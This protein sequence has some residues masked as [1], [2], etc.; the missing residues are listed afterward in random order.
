[1]KMHLVQVEVACSQQDTNTE[2][3]V[4]QTDKQTNTSGDD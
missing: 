1:M 2:A 4:Q 3:I